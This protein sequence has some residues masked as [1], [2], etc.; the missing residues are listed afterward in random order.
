V[1]HAAKL[2]HRRFRVPLRVTHRLAPASGATESAKPAAAPLS[3][4]DPDVVTNPSK[5][6]GSDPAGTEI[7]TPDRA[8]DAE[9]LQRVAPGSDAAAT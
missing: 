2:R 8:S 5:A 6:L 1:A 7:A 3:E 4:D 9:P